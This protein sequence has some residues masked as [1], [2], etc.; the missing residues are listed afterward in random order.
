[1]WAIYAIVAAVL[2]AIVSTLYAAGSFKS[3][4]PREAGKVEVISGIYGPEDMD[5]DEQAGRLYISS[6][7]RRRTLR[8]LP[9]DDAIWALD[10]DAAAAPRRLVTDYTG[11]FHP[12]G[13]SFLRKD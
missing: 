3:I 2:Y 11:E 12:H 8:G 13:I 4:S 7:N 10:I 5:L 1:M 9:S 6:C